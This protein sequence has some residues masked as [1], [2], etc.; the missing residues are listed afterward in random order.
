MQAPFI[1]SSSIL[2]KQLF[3]PCTTDEIIVTDSLTAHFRKRDRTNTYTTHAHSVDNL[4]VVLICNCRCYA[5]WDGASMKQGRYLC[6]LLREQNPCYHSGIVNLIR[7]RIR[8]LISEP[9]PEP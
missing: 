7:E 6:V 4:T 3:G 2:Q 1:A 5:V 8:V 9:E